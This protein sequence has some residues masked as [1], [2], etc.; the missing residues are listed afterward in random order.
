MDWFT[1]PKKMKTI[2]TYDKLLS[3]ISELDEVKKTCNLYE[4]L[5][6]D[7]N[8]NLYTDGIHLSNAGHKLWASKI[9][10]C[11]DLEHQL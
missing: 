9:Y 2:K 1:D 3:R 8:E 7:F 4:Y 11:L 5:K 6:K 10:L